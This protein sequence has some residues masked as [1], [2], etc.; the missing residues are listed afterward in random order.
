MFVHTSVKQSVTGNFEGWGL[1]D[2]DYVAKSSLTTVSVAK[3]CRDL[4]VLFFFVWRISFHF[5]L[6][7][8][9]FLLLKSNLQ[10]KP[11]NCKKFICNMTL[12]GHPAMFTL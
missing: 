8:Q 9:D 4:Y 1:R 5:M 10:F 7:N 12:H 3:C 11:W 6:L 2:G